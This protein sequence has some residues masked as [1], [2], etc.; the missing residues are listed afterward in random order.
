[1]GIDNAQEQ[2]QFK[3]RHDVS[4]L[5]SR[6]WWCWWCRLFVKLPS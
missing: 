4:L 1:M 2:L 5:V 3:R 6:W